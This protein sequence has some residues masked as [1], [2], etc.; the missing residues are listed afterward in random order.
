M[1]KMRLIVDSG[2]AW[3]NM[4]EDESFL[5]AVAE[6]KAMETLRLYTWL[7]PGVSIGY[8]QSIKDEVDID[9][10]KRMG[11]DVVRRITGGGAVFHEH[12]VTYCIVVHEKNIEGDIIES[13]KYLCTPV[14][15]FLRRHGIDARFMPI[16]DI[17]AN[18][19]KISG[20]AQTRRKGVIMQHGTL[21]LRTEPEKMFSLLKIGREKIAD[22]GIESIEERVTSLER[23]SGMRWDAKRV[24]DELA[25]CF[26]EHMGVE[27]VKGVL[28][29][30]EK[31]KWKS[32]RKNTDQKSGIS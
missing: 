20:S 10:A 27:L 16:N 14:V 24:I 26:A 7:R 15:N 17:I 4:A 18:G 9:T 31:R 6:K 13:Y 28:S 25:E 5:N 3:Q 12:E 8:F 22:K 30:F 19:K 11:V 29:D 21:L 23:E 1:R 32:L 2:N